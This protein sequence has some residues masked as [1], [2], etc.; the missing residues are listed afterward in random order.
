MEKNGELSP[1]QKLDQEVVSIIGNQSLHGFEKA[2]MLADAV[3]RLESLLTDEYMR[4][5]MKLQGHKLGFRTDKDNEGGYG[6]TVVKR[7]LIEAVLT[8]VQPAG[9]QFNIIAG[10]CYITKEGFGYLL[11]K[12][13]MLNYD[14]VPELPRIKD[15]SAAIVMKI[16]WTIG[17]N[18][19]NTENLDIPIRVNKMMGTDAII[20][21][22][23]RK[24]RA[25]LYNT[26][27]GCE[28]ADGDISDPN[29]VEDQKEQLRQTNSDTQSK[30]QLP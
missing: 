12:V 30:I 2:Y 25:W 27:S 8:G 11:K 28:I 14:I 16:G 10:N 1:I 17:N 29:I 21:K 9:N 23:T 24:A 20:G 13:Q 22:A 7:C 6:V 4:P 5:I 26:I 15:N 19:R 3:S 18:T